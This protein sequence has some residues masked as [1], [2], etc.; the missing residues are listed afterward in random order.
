MASSLK[1]DDNHAMSKFAF[2]SNPLLTFRS[3]DAVSSN[4]ATV[5]LEQG[6]EE[7]LDHNAATFIHLELWEPQLMEAAADAQPPMH[8]VSSTVSR[9]FGVKAE[10]AFQASHVLNGSECV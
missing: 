3:R 8:T 7:K 10:D 5:D 1:V 9:N 2:P 4:A 6:I